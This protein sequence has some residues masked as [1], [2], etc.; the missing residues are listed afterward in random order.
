MFRLKKLAPIGLIIGETWDQ[1]LFSTF[2]LPACFKKLAGNE[3]PE[4]TH[5]TWNI[6]CAQMN[7]YIDFS[8]YYKVINACF[9]NCLYIKVRFDLLNHISLPEWWGINGHIHNSNS[10]Y[11]NI[12]VFNN[13]TDLFN[14]L[15]NQVSFL[16]N[17][18]TSSLFHDNYTIHFLLMA[19]LL[20]FSWYV[21]DIRLTELMNSAQFCAFW[22]KDDTFYN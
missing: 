5:V 20:I 16:G 22:F 18:T 15:N 17:L 13:C 9:T 14:M 2:E 8:I 10:Y 19:Y 3:T 12:F 6:T 4:K 1:G 11:I 7:R 21:S